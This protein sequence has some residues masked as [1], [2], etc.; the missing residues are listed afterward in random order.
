MLSCSL[1]NALEISSNFLF[2]WTTITCFFSSAQL[3]TDYFQKHTNTYPSWIHLR[4]PLRFSSTCSVNRP[5]RSPYSQQTPLQPLHYFVSFS[6]F[7]SIESSC[8]CS[9]CRLRFPR[10]ETRTTCRSWRSTCFQGSTDCSPSHTR[11]SLHCSE[12][13]SMDHHLD[14]PQKQSR[15]WP[16]TWVRRRIIWF[17]PYLCKLSIS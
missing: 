4:E 9:C 5:S 17:C 6:W 8:C 2:L 3:T 13:N 1:A 7:R 16:W 15:C 10:R 12:R 11:R 14:P